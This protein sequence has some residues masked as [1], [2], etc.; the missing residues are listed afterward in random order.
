VFIDRENKTTFVIGID[1]PLTH[2]L[3][4]I[5][6]RKTK[7]DDNVALEIKNVLQLHNAPIHIRVCRSHNSG[8]S[9]QQK[10]AERV[11]NRN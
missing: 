3:S 1:I 5:E 7:K 8:R 9:G 4:N 6:A 11:V 2:S 10:L